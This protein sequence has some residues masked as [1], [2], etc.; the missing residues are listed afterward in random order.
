M[1]LEQIKGIV[2]RIAMFV[3]AYIVGKGWLPASVS[4]DVVAAVVLIF[5]II[6]GWK[7]NTPKALEKAADAA[8]S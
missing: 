2:E 1:N 4:A 3:V 5:T 8:K 7:V 6:W